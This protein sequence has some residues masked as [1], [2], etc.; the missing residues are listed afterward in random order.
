PPGARVGALVRSRANRARWDRDETRRSRGRRPGVEAGARPHREPRSAG[1]HLP[2]QARGLG[3]RPHPARGRAE[4]ARALG[5]QDRRRGVS[6]APPSLPAKHPLRSGI[7][8]ILVTEVCFALM[9]MA[10][11]WGAADLPGLEIGGVRFLGGAVVAWAM[12]RARHAPL[13]VG[14]QKN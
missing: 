1:L 9:R 5:R 2:S 7:L 12:A 10:T 3:A 8:W 14:D 4:A 6:T 13:R 11:R